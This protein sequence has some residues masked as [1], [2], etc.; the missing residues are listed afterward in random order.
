MVRISGVVLPAK[1]RIEFALTYINGIGRSSSK[2]ILEE[3]KV[4]PM[5]MSDDLTEG[6]EALLRSI[7]EKYETEGD[8]KRRI[9]MDIRR[10]QDTGSYRGYRHRRRLPSRGQTSRRNARTRRGK[11]RTG[12]SGR[13][14][15]TKT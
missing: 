12:L 4:D 9:S 10:L 8:L 3:A 2:K 11:K 15:L 14:K 5:K 13:V 7:I 1:K 6:E